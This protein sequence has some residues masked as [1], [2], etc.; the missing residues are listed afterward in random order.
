MDYLSGI[1]FR[2]FEPKNEYLC[3]DSR[4]VFK[5]CIAN[6]K[7]Y[8]KTGK[9]KQCA[10]SDIDIECIPLRKKYSSC[11]RLAVDRTKDFRSDERTK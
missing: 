6:S 11:K 4:E 8:E 5:N 9:F 7:C 10:T 1:W 2:F 3:K